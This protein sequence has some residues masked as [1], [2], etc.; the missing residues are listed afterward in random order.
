MTTADEAARDLER[1]KQRVAGELS[2]LQ[3]KQAE[4]LKEAERKRTELEKIEADLQTI[5]ADIA[6][7]EAA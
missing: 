2:R 6:K 5:E 4:K 7:L 3:S 1:S